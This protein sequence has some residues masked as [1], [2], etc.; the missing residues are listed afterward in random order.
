MV[1]IPFGLEDRLA[2]IKLLATDV[3]GVLTDGGM[4]Y[5]EQGDELKN[6]TP[7]MGRV[8]SCSDKQG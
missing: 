6:S 8:L 7:A 5:S 2:G 1:T 3:D 4:Y